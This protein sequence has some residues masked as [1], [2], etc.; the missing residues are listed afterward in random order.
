MKVCKQ[1][2]LRL[3]FNSPPETAN[4]WDN[5]TSLRQWRWIKISQ[6]KKPIADSIAQWS[7]EE[8]DVIMGRVAKG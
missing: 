2:A 8:D 7:F 6:E 4:Q 3:K 1:L 5:G